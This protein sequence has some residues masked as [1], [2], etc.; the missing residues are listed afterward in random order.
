MNSTK[1]FFDLTSALQRQKALVAS[2]LAIGL[3]LAVAVVV[4]THVRYTATSTMLM[5]TEAPSYDIQHSSLLTAKPLAALDMASLVTS[6]AV[7]TKFRKDLG[8]DVSIEQLRRRIRAKSNGESTVMPIQ[9]TDFSEDG[10]VRG[11][12][13]LAT[14]VST[15]YRN[16]ATRRIDLLIADLQSQ[17]KMH[18][19]AL[20]ALDS[21][22]QDSARQYPYVDLKDGDDHSIYTKL[23]NLIAQ[24]DE[25]AATIAADRSN[26]RISR[27]F[28][29]NARPAASREVVESDPLYANARSAYARD[30]A[31]LAHIESFGSPDY[32]GLGELRDIVSREQATLADTKQIALK[33]GPAANSFY[34]TARDNLTKAQAALESNQSKKAA[35]DSQIDT[36]NAQLSKGGIGIQVAQIRRRREHEQNLYA[37]LEMRSMQAIADRSQ[38]SAEGSLIVMDP[39]QSARLAIWSTGTFAALGVILITLWAAIILGLERDRAD[40]RFRTS[41]DV[42]SAYNSPV[43]GTLA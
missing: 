9:Y 37:A 28:I 29:D 11:S 40:R 7:L 3:V 41:G 4:L 18:A 2:V 27:N 5:I 23:I 33:N 24:R 16:L 12:N 38:A 25:V 22:L 15:F 6:D 17:T 34:A 1:T 31:Q 14:N 39:A 21:Q 30:V 32:P 43:I 26:A 13:L 42:E 8:E 20:A 35:I 19:A 10:A 36:I